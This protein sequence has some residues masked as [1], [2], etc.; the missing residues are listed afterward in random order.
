[1]PI[2]VDAYE[3]DGSGGFFVQW[4]DPSQPVTAFFHLT[5]QACAELVKA[6]KLKRQAPTD[7]FA[8]A[9]D[10]LNNDGVSDAATIES[11]RVA[12]E[13]LVDD[14]KD[15]RRRGL[16]HNTPHDQLERARKGKRVE[17]K[18]RRKGDTGLDG[19]VRKQGKKHRVDD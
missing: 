7:K 3:S 6:H 18:W 16:K 5:D 13:E 14:I 11:W 4:S 17:A 19:F 1:M 9:V 8:Q 10:D 12:Y 2:V 15:L